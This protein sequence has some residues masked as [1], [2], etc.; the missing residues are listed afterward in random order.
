MYNE[1]KI[2]LFLI[3]YIICFSEIVIFQKYLINIFCQ[4]SENN[5]MKGNSMFEIWH[6][7]VMLKYRTICIL[8]TKIYNSN[9][10]RHYFLERHSEVLTQEANRDQ[11]WEIWFRFY[12]FIAIV[13]FST[14]NLL[15]LLNIPI[16]HMHIYYVKHLF[17]T[18]KI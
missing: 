17:G 4:K 1:R 12:S 7:K 14:Y 15:I 6:H 2:Y 18:S 11:R 5:S 3:H 8:A 10:E 9:L 16:T 13:S